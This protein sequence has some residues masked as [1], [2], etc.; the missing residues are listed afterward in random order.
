MPAPTQWTLILPVKQTAIAKSRLTGISASVRRRLALAFA[1]DAADAALSCPLVSEVVAVTNDEQAS[2][3]LASL[4]VRVVADAPDAGLNAALT[5]AA[6]DARRRAPGA[7]LAVMSAD[8]PAVRAVDLGTALAA[9]PQ[10]RWFLADEAGDGTT[11][12]GAPAPFDLRPA[13]GAGSSAAHRASGAVQLSA[14]E[15]SR[16]R[17]DVDTAEDLRA[18]LLL[19]VGASTARVLADLPATI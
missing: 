1:C 6:A 11:M 13:F 4:G 15:V 18:A 7:S 3:A 19:G 10:R 5:W 16:L 2:R 12:L 8:L 9:A 14:V 17:V